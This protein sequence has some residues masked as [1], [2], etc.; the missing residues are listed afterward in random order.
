MEVDPG[1]PWAD[2]PLPVIEAAFKQAAENGAGEHELA[3]AADER[4]RQAKL[5]RVA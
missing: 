4:L 5:D 2:L 3:A 1:A